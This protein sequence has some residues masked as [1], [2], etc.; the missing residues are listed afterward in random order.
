[1]GL[2]N[3]S[4]ILKIGL[5]NR[6]IFDCIEDIRT[7]DSYIILLTPS[8]KTYNQEMAY[9][10]SKFKHLILICGHYEGFDERI[11]SICD[12]E[13]SIGDYILTGGEVPAI[14]LV[15]S[16]TRLL[17]GVITDES[18]INDSFHN[19]LLDYPTYTKP[20]EYRGMK[21]PE[22]LL[23]GNPK[24]IRAWQDEQALQRTKELRPELLKG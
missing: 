23:S 6:S 22:V 12:M 19:H 3:G 24:L 9:Q 18:H 11:K 20:R 21:V 16:I 14:V 5:E 2:N 17:P 1:M 8:G 7:E 10:F 13:L 15:D 4:I